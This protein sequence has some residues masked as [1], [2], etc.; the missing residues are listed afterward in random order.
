LLIRAARSGTDDLTVRDASG[1]RVL[2]FVFGF[3][4]FGGSAAGA[5]GVGFKGRDVN[6]SGAE[7]VEMM[8]PKAE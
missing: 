2:D 3:S 4:S 5:G 7:M 8:P 6:A 1:D